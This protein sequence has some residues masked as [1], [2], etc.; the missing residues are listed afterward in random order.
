MR[1]PHQI[2]ALRSGLKARNIL[3]WGNAPG[4]RPCVDGAL[5][6]RAILAWGNAPG[7]QPSSIRGLKARA[8]CRARH[9]RPALIPHKPLIERDTVLRKHRTH[10]SL[11][12]APLMMRALPIDIP[13][14]RRPITQPHGK[15]GIPA[16]PTELR[17]LRPLCLDPL[18]RRSLQPLHQLRHGLR[19][20]EKQRNVNMVGNSA[21][22]HANILRTNGRSH[23]RMHLA[24]NRCGQQRPSPLRA[25]DQMHQHVGGRLRHANDYSAGL[26]PAPVT[27]TTSWGDA[28]GYKT[29]GLQPARPQTSLNV[30]RS[31]GHL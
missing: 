9:I 5:K 21:N 24:S 1:P 8:K 29:T 2:T 7:C 25:E 16:L 28:P 20:R 4:A 22:P 26:Q 19:P 10:L 17:K 30:R 15:H 18:G 13:H 23:V 3:A 12:I 27:A 11:E 31:N 14:Q 6:A